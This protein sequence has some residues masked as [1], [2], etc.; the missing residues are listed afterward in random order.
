MA[1]YYYPHSAVGTA[2]ITSKLLKIARKNERTQR[3][4]VYLSVFNIF[5]RVKFSEISFRVRSTPDKIILRQV[6]LVSA[7]EQNI[8]FLHIVLMTKTLSFFAL[9]VLGKREELSGQKRELDG[10]RK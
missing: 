5:K 9:F 7:A 1:F 4:L 3:Y 2:F 6:G 10:N 8:G